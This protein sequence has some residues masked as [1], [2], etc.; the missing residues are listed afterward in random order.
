MAAT[1]SKLFGSNKISRKIPELSRESQTSNRK[2]HHCSYLYRLLNY[3]KKGEAL[4]A[5]DGV[6]A[7]SW[8]FIQNS[9][10]LGILTSHYE[11]YQSL[12][13]R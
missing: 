5:T 8:L 3:L 9:N 11:G 13:Y 6:G 2:F 4:L 7:S 10:K 1:F 12:R